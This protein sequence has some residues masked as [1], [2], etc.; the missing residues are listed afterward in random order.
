MKK[1]Y[2]TKEEVPT[3]CK[4][5]CDFVRAN[6][7]PITDAISKRTVEFIK[8]NK[9][10]DGLTFEECVHTGIFDGLAIFWD[11]SLYAL[12]ETHLLKTIDDV[13]SIDET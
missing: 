3:V 13:S 10:T 8:E 12:L 11:R 6:L 9:D 2:I 5:V 7:H 4:K 1:K